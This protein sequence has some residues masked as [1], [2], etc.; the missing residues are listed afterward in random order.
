MNTI[1]LMGRVDAGEPAADALEMVPLTDQERARAR[2]ALKHHKR[3]I[4]QQNRDQD[5]RDLESAL[6]K[7]A[8]EE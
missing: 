6:E 5:A 4:E 7:M 8:R 1:N 3:K 2:R